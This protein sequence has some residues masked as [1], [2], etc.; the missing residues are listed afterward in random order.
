MLRGS[1]R[2]IV[3]AIIVL[4]GNVGTNARAQDLANG[5]KLANNWCSKCH[6]IDGK[7]PPMGKTGAVPSFP[8]IAHTKSTTATSLRTFLSTSHA[9]MPDYNLSQKEIGDVSEYILSLRD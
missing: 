1:G 8:A 2:H 9:T 4:L 7:V 5:K 6:V 3:L